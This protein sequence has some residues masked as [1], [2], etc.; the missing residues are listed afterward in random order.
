MSEQAPDRLWSGIQISK[1]IAGTLAAVTAA[2]LGSF[3]GVA[4]TL[5]GAAL[6]SVVGSVGTEIFNNSLKRSTKHLQ[7]VTP[8]FIKT[9]AAVGTP[10]VAAAVAEEKPS[11]TVIPEPPRKLRWGHIG[12]A[13]LTLFVLSMGALSVFEAFTDKPIS[14]TVRHIPASGT[15][16][17]GNT[18]EKPDED[19]KQA[20]SVSENPSDNESADP[21]TTSSE[22][23]APEETSTT[24]EPAREPTTEA[25]T[26]APVQTP[27][28]DEQQQPDEQLAPQQDQEQDST[29]E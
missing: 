3:L 17:F 9:P 1:V 24:T 26:Q 25:T 22:S 19:S 14:A 16:L 20:P 10:P 18:K 12:L 29:T 6:A 5:A 11:H 23:P 28:A 8:A 27:P 7:T 4:G 15:T 2:V 21:D 13:A